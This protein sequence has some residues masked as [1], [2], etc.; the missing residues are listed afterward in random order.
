MRPQPAKRKTDVKK[1]TLTPIFNQEFV[2]DWVDDDSH[3][4]IEVLDHDEV[5]GVNHSRAACGGARR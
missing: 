5:M 3:I 4:T 2:I 1:K